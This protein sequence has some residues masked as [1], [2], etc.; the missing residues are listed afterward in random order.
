MGW[1]YYHLDHSHPVGATEDSFHVPAPLR[2]LVSPLPPQS[3]VSDQKGSSAPCQPRARRPGQPKQPILCYPTQTRRFSPK[4]WLMTIKRE[5]TQAISFFRYKFSVCNNLATR[6]K[7]NKHFQDLLKKQLQ[8]Q[9]FQI[10]CWGQENEFPRKWQEP[11]AP[12]KMWARWQVDIKEDIT[13]WGL[14]KAIHTN[15]EGDASSPRGN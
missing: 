7:A 6:R 4:N 14:P 15:R 5:F 8:Q 3:G 11:D 1:A 10:L 2:P 9:H 13:R 12:G